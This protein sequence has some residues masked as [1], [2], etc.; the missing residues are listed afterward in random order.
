MLKVKSSYNFELQTC[1]TRVNFSVNR[2]EV[3]R[4]PASL[5]QRLES[6][7]FD[8]DSKMAGHEIL[9]VCL[10]WHLIKVKIWLESKHFWPGYLLSSYST[11]TC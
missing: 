9:D 2:E 10:L 7:G 11:G 6:T 3:K 5:Y 4:K 8:V 1:G